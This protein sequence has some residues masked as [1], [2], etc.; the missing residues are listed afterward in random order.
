MADN[1]ARHALITKFEQQYKIYGLPKP[2]INRVT[3]KWNADDLIESFDQEDLYDAIRF[4][5]KVNKSP[6]WLGFC[7]SAGEIIDSMKAQRED[8]QFRKEMREKAK[9]WLT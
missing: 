9:A 8:I 3:E 5:F 2:P 6:T 1:K 4:Y 7:R